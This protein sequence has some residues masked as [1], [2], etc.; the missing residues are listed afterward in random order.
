MVRVVVIDRRCAAIG[1]V[2]VPR[3][4][5]VYQ[6]GL[7]RLREGVFEGT[8]GQRLGGKGTARFDRG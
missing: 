3:W 2:Q 6:M 5:F 1:R 7:V 4:Q 8:K